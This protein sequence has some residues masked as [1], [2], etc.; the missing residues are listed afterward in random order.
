MKTVFI[1]TNEVNLFDTHISEYPVRAFAFK[2]EVTRF[3]FRTLIAFLSIINLL[4]K[5]ANLRV[6]RSYCLF[7]V[8]K[9][10]P[11]VGQGCH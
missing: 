8:R 4:L 2:K 6:S 1:R 10:Y 5:L 3:A 11:S 9:R 7:G